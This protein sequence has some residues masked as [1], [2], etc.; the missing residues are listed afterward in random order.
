MKHLFLAATVALGL[1]VSCNKEENEIYATSKG[2]VATVSFTDGEPATRSATAEAETWEKTLNTVT[3]F[4]F[5]PSGDLMVKRSFSATELS[6]KKATFALPDAVPGNVCEFYA[7]ANLDVANVGDKTTLTALLERD[8]AS[9]NGTFAEVST[10]AIRTGGFVM[11]GMAT[12]TIAAGSTTDVAI[13]LKRTVAKVAVQVTPSPRFGSLYQGAVRINSITLSNG[14]TQTPVFQ[15]DYNPGAFNFSATQ[16]SDAASGKYRNL[17]YLFECPARN[18]GNRVKAII[19]A[20]YDMDGDFSTA[21]GQS[22]MTYEVELDGTSGG[23][24]RRN[25][26]YRVDITINGLSGHDASL[27]ITPAEW[28]L[29]VTQTVELGA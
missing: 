11:S 25:G 28:E 5:D 17:F 18:V 15:S 16:A 1:L 12:E 24:I 20:T 2:A 22:S 9:Y 4:V 7:V 27:T 6:A 8:A 14:A 21:A 26:Y 3:M 29:P 13:T 19:H 10:K 23:E